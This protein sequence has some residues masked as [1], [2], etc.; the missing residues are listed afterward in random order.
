MVSDELIELAARARVD[1]AEGPARV[2]LFGFRARGEG[3]E[4]SDVDLLVVE[5]EVEDRFGESVR[6]SRLAGELRVPA[7]VIVVSKTQVE[8]WGSVPGT[9]LHEALAEGRVV[10]ET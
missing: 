10:A 8:D 6:L 3:A 9:M 1:A 5:R 2:I 7:D 4:D